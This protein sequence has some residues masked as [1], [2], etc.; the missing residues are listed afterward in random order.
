MRLVPPKLTVEPETKFVPITVKVNLAL[1]AVTQL[2]LS[3]LMLGTGVIVNV[4]GADVA[5]AQGFTTL[6]DTVPEVATIAA[7]TVTT[8]CVEEDDV[9]VRVVPPKLTSEPETKFVPATVKVKS[10]LPAVTQG[11]LSELMVE[12][13]R[14]MSQP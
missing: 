5:P 9:G 6:T 4:A 2:G 13:L 8:S 10:A 12:W 14:Y 3:E 11:G 1:P 7:G